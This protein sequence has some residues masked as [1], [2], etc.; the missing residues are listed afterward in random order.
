MPIPLQTLCDNIRHVAS[1]AQTDWGSLHPILVHFPIVLLMIVP[2]F[3][4]AGLALSQHRSL[5]YAC[6]LAV[7]L[8]GTFSLYITASSGESAGEKLNK[9]PQEALAT[10]E[11]H[12]ELAELTE[13]VFLGLSL[14]GIL[15]IFLY[16]IKKREMKRGREFSIW[17]IYL[18]CYIFG[19]II[20]L[21]TAHY[22]GK[23][24]HQHHLH[25]S[26]YS[27]DQP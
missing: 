17:A 22:G 16:A 25:T 18:L 13:K 4:L 3:L 11:T 1:A 23:L 10:F 19:L 15:L 20:L 12:Y 24:V 27:K 8:L 6:A 26:L 9:L 2:L 5:L 21:N 7:L 14:A